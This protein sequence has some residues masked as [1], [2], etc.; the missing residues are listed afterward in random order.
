MVATRSRH[1]CS[2]RPPA[3]SSSSRSCGLGRERARQFQPL[4]LEQRQRAGESVG[5]RGEAGQFAGSRQRCA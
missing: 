3:I 2:V 4:A 5:L 1:S